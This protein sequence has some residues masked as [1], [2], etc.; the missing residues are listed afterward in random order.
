MAFRIGPGTPEQRRDLAD[1][2]KR[3]TEIEREIRRVKGPGVDTSEAEAT[4]KRYR[5]TIAHLEKVLF[6]RTAG[7][8]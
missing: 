6:T 3:L 4:A 8:E 2:K 7:T 5:E 1:A